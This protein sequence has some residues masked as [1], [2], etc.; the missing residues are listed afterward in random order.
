MSAPYV[1]PDAVTTAQ[2]GAP[3]EDYDSVIDTETDLPS[4]SLNTLIGNVAALCSVCPK[5]IVAINTALGTVLDYRSIWGNTVAARPTV[6]INGIG[7][8]SLTWA[9]TYATLHPSDT[10]AKSTQLNGGV[11]TVQDPSAHFAVVEKVSA[12][13]LRVRVFD[14]AGVAQ[15]NSILL[16]VSLWPRIPPSLSYW[17]RRTLAS[18]SWT[19]ILLLTR[20]ASYLLSSTIQ[21]SQTLWRCRMCCPCFG[22]S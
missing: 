6:A 18:L 7:D 1:L 21:S 11:A 15:D 17:P 2:L 22:W 9:A 4:A 12:T 20:S 8:V 13:V 16:V 14:A 10:T 3:Y 19:S 5:A